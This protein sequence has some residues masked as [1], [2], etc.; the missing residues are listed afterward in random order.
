MPDAILG[1]S[2]KSYVSAARTEAV[3]RLRDELLIRNRP[4]SFTLMGRWFDGRD[5]TSILYHY[6]K[7]KAA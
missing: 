6:A 4:P 7:G 1:R 5:H 2:R 3:V